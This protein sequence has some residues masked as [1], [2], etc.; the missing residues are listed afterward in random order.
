MS[1]PTPQRKMLKE[2]KRKAVRKQ[3][4]YE[5]LPAKVAFR[6]EQKA[7]RTFKVSI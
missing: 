6:R 2:L 5:A 4:R 7:G 3:K 1:K